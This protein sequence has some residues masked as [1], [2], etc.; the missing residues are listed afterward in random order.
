MINSADWDRIS[1]RISRLT[2]D[3][4]AALNVLIDVEK[5][6]KHFQRKKEA[7]ENLVAAWQEYAKVSH[8]TK[9]AIVEGC[10]CF[11]DNDGEK[12]DEDFIAGI[13]ALH[14]SPEGNITI[15]LAD[16]VE[17]DI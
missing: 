7:A 12:Y 8:F 17:F 11:R 2:Y 16:V 4:L 13:E 10:V 1:D 9:D 5:S 6:K 3:E 14:S 15:T